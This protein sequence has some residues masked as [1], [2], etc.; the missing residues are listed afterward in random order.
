VHLEFTGTYCGQHRDI[1]V[2]KLIYEVYFKDRE[3]P[4]YVRREMP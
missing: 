1:D 3:I 4:A 2:S